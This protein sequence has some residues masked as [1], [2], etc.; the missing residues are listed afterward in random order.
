MDYV[1][2]S[3]YR[4]DAKY[5]FLE[6]IENNTSIIKDVDNQRF[7]ITLNSGDTIFFL[8]DDEYHRWCKGRT[9]KVVSA[10]DEC[11]YRS[12]YVVNEN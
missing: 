11:T 7:I 6:F 2:V 3:M 10:K 8:T 1:S 4:Q 12:G 9:Y 5:A